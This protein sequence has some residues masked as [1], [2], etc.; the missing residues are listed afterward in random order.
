MPPDT[1]QPLLWFQED[2]ITFDNVQLF[3]VDAFNMLYILGIYGSNNTFEGLESTGCNAQNATV[4]IQDIG[5]GIAT[6]VQIT[7]SRFTSSPTR[8][9]HIFNSTV[10]ITESVFDG[11]STP[12]SNGGAILTTSN[13]DNFIGIS[14]CSFRNN[15]ATGLEDDQGYVLCSCLDKSMS[16]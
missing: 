13:A 11:L 9:L 1:N 4:Y 3:N 2:G 8:A 10:I 15:A 12:V 6:S 16:T 5:N 14:N 7:H